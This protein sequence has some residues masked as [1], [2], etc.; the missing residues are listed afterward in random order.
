M[1]ASTSSAKQALYLLSMCVCVLAAAEAPAVPSNKQPAT[2]SRRSHSGSGSVSEA[3]S[4][5]EHALDSENSDISS[6]SSDSDKD[7]DFR[8]KPSVL[9]SAWGYAMPTLQRKRTHSGSGIA[10]PSADGAARPA[11][12]AGKA[13]DSPP[14]AAAAAA[15]PP[16]RRKAAAAAAKPTAPLPP[17]GSYYEYAGQRVLVPEWPR[18]KTDIKRAISKH[19]GALIGTVLSEAP[20]LSQPGLGFKGSQSIRGLSEWGKEVLLKVRALLSALEK[21]DPKAYADVSRLPYWATEQ[22]LAP[23]ALCLTTHVSP[24]RSAPSAHWLCVSMHV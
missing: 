6:T 9:A 12:A 5:S 2:G 20:A 18:K 1:Q 10:R 22:H 14:P 8:V 13:V 24:V 15:A 7:P 16:P 4:S 3:K 21:S 17:P 19:L 23:N 11:K